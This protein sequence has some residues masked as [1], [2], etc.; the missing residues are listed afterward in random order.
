MWGAVAGRKI[1]SPS[2]EL[3]LECRT[4][5]WLPAQGTLIRLWIH[6]HAKDIQ[7]YNQQRQVFVVESSL[8]I[9]S[10]QS[11][12]T[13]KGTTTHQ[14]Q[15]S[16]VLEVD[17][18]VAHHA[19]APQHTKLEQSHAWHGWC[20]QGQQAGQ[21]PQQHTGREKNHSSTPQHT[22]QRD[23]GEQPPSRWRL[24]LFRPLLLVSNSSKDPYLYHTTHTHT[25]AHH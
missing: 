19:T 15:Q 2:R 17:L 4:Y 23:R 8:F 10:V 3:A 22:R 14:T 21:T 12:C 7:Q 1:P 25:R 9:Y 6:K 20:I 16:K 11:K 13:Q 18:K 5:G 24:N